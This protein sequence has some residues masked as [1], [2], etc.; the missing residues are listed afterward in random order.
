MT[1]FSPPPYVDRCNIREIP[2]RPERKRRPRH[3]L[4]DQGR[5]A[6]RHQEART[7]GLSSHDE[8][9]GVKE[10]GQGDEAKKGRDQ[11]GAKGAKEAGEGGELRRE[12]TFWAFFGSP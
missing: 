7:G 2:G 3:R 12:E 1:L 4:Q 8:Q 5:P 11:G 6:T 10:T 9:P